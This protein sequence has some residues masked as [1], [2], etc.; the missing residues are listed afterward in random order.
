M[1]KTGKFTEINIQS[2]VK[3]WLHWIKFGAVSYSLSCNTFKDVQTYPKNHPKKHHKKIPQKSTEK[4]PQKS[5]KKIRFF[6]KN[7]E[8]GCNVRKMDFPA[9]RVSLCLQGSCG[10]KNLKFDILV[11][12]PHFVLLCCSTRA[13]RDLIASLERH[14]V[15]YCQ[16]KSVNNG[17]ILDEYIWT[18]A[19]LFLER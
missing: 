17:Q 1:V 15:T 2:N 10:L 14:L 4:S 5:P 3:F 6:S 12:F 19:I 8:K 9:P 16:H 13:R 18:L 7:W 11:S